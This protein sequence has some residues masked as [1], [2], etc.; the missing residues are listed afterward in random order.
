MI[1]RE[2]VIIHE[3]LEEMIQSITTVYLTLWH[4]SRLLQRTQLWAVTLVR[5]HRLHVMAQ[6]LQNSF[7]LS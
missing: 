6:D 7:V 1:L 4:L 5:L 2:L 3:V